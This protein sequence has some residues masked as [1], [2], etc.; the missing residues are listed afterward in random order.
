MH[1]AAGFTVK[2]FFRSFEWAGTQVT[3]TFGLL[4]LFIALLGDSSFGSGHS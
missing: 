4:V 3:D 1:T 2:D